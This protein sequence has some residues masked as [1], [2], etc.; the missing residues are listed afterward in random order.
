MSASSD[1][2]SE[3][4]NYVDQDGDLTWVEEFKVLEEENQNY[5]GQKV[6]LFI[7]YS[8]LM[9]TY[10]GF[11]RPYD[12]PRLATPFDLFL[13]TACANRDVNDRTLAEQFTK[14]NVQELL[15]VTDGDRPD[16][17][18]RITLIRPQVTPRFVIDPSYQLWNPASRAFDLNPQIATWGQVDFAATKELQIQQNQAQDEWNSGARTAA[19]AAVSAWVIPRVRYVEVIQV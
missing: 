10:I 8:L 3:K 13:R 7:I 17:N 18:R 19:V 15:L 12:V 5:Q 9:I 6:A 1:D 2:F 11:G 14:Y 4:I 16:N